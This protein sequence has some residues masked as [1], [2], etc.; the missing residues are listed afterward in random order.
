MPYTGKVKLQNE[1]IVQIIEA[2]APRKRDVHNLL[3]EH[4][5]VKEELQIT[6][7]SLNTETYHLN[8]KCFIFKMRSLWMIIL[9]KMLL[10]YLP[11]KTEFMNVIIFW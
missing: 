9:L 6:E 4:C 11:F 3:I 10:M 2:I 8:T 5:L 7:F 1:A